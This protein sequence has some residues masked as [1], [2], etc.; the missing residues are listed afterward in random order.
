MIDTIVVLPRMNTLSWT[1]PEGDTGYYLQLNEPGSEPNNPAGFFTEYSFYDPY[2]I[3]P[4]DDDR[5]Y[6]FS[7]ER[8]VFTNYT[9]TPAGV[10]TQAV[11]ATFGNM[12]TQNSSN[13]S[14]SGGSISGVTISPT[15]DIFGSNGAISVTPGIKSINKSGSAIAATLAAPAGA[16]DV[17]YIISESSY[18]HVVT[19]TSLIQNGVSGGNKT[20]LTF[21]AYAGASITLMGNNSGRWT[22]VANNNVT[23]S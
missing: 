3:G 10:Y 5:E 22:V 1:P 9:I 7:F 13:V 21:A 6:L 11:R 2:S 17:I 4:F 14:I 20:T 12:S 23:I 16:G 19:A 8:T 15:Y 18:A